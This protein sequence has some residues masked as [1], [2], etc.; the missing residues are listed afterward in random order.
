MQAISVWAQRLGLLQDLGQMASFRNLFVI[1]SVGLWN[2]YCMYSSAEIPGPFRDP[3][4][5]YTTFFLKRSDTTNER[6]KVRHPLLNARTHYIAL[7]IRMV[8]S[9][10]GLHTHEVTIRFKHH[11]FSSRSRQTS[12]GGRVEVEV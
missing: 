8:N 11:S 7:R 3:G 2:W 6:L 5:S 9:P 4:S 1:P 10:Y 12:T